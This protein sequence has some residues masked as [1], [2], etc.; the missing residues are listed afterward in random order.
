MENSN[1]D[2]TLPTQIN[3][4]DAEPSVSGEPQPGS[5]DPE[6]MGASSLDQTVPTLIMAEDQDAT[7][8][9]DTIPPPSDQV[10]T[11]T[12]DSGEEPPVSPDETSQ[13]SKRPSWRIWALVGF[14]AFILLAFSSAFLG[15]R[16]GINQRQGAE[17]AQAS[18]LAAEQYHLALQD[19]EA[20][21][22][23][24]ARQRFEYIWEHAQI[25]VTAEEEDN[26]GE[27][28]ATS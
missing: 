24:R 2:E 27:K 4:E 20:R 21:N 10:S 9:E 16:S 28:Q 3:P 25:P 26:K 19:M 13:T 15:Y 5:S 8:F 18:Q 22:Y 7:G 6:T 17:A 1:F 11:M 23:Y 14:F 12:G